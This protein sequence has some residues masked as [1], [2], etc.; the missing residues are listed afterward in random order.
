MLHSDVLAYIKGKGYINIKEISS[1]F[2]EPP[3]KIELIL[4]QL[5]ELGYLEYAS[6]NCSLKACN[7]C[8]INKSCPYINTNNRFYK[9]KTHEK[10]R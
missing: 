6:N 10:S 9:V 7:S 8:P 1:A 2:H 4:Q 5:V 3:D